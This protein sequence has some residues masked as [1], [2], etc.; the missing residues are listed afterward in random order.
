MMVTIPDLLTADQVEHCRRTLLER[1]RWEDGRATAGHLAIRAKRNLQLDASDPVAVELGNLILDALGANPVFVSATLPLK[2]LPPRFNR[3]E[4]GGEYG[5]HVDGAILTVPGTTHRIRTDVSA[6][7]FFSAPE[8]YDGGE[9]VIEDTYGTH[10]VKLPAGHIVLY[11]G[12]SLHRVKPVTRGVRLASFF[13]IQS[14]VKDDAQRALLFELDASI[15]QLSARLP[16]APELE[17]L[18]G[19]Y[20]NLVRRWSDT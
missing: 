11:P 8:D 4:H 12:T 16:D 14:L 9:L 15:Q 13:W 20:H 5:N 19:V 3:Y 18:A 17:R 10:E 6:T 7:L 1:G 2:V